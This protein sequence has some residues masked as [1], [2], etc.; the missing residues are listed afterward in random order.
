MTQCSGAEEISSTVGLAGAGEEGVLAP[1]GRRTLDNMRQL[2]DVVADAIVDAIALGTLRFGQRIVE[3]D[4]ADQLKVSRVP[5]RDAIKILNSQGILTTTPNRGARVAPLDGDVADQ[6]FEIRVALERIAVRDAMR[7]Y[8]CD[9][10]QLDGLRE[11]IARMRRM[12]SWFVWVGFRKCDIAFHREI[13]RASG[14]DVVLKLWETIARH[15][16]IIF[17]RELA[18][19]HD[20]EVVISQHLKLLTLFEKGDRRIEQI[21]EKHILRLRRSVKS[22]TPS[23]KVKVATP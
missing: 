8:R 20:F 7:A 21:I 15:V 11:I 16:T 1:L 6:V 4:L 3:S 12:A 2:G 13:C 19:E 14:N 9:R 10:Q 17:G 22:T 18:S 23:S 5:I